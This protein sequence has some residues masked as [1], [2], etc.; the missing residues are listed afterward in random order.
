MALGDCDRRGYNLGV[1]ETLTLE[2]DGGS[3]GNPG[4]AGIGVVVRAEDR[5][6]LVTLGRFIGKATNNVAEYRALITAM[7]EAKKLGATK[8]IIRGD[9]ELIIRQM[10]GQYK[11][12]HPDMKVLF[13]E[14]QR[15]IR[16]F[17]SAKIEHNLRH[18]NEL[19]DKLANLAMDRR[20]DVTEAEE[21]PIDMP[22]PEATKAGDRF[23]CPKCGCEI[24]VRKPSSVRPH[25]LKPF[26]CQC[27]TRMLR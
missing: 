21:S 16:G 11:V 7:E 8:I 22:S 1:N 15:A 13:D 6:P 10:T 18:K 27:G 5:T 20:Q 14:A 23:K 17:A 24:E 12:K 3:R 26:L 2:F 25:Q 4:P 19:A 9:S